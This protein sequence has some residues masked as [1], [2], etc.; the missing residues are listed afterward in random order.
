MGAT[1]KNNVYIM[2]AGSLSEAR[3]QDSGRWEDQEASTHK[4]TPRDG[5]QYS[6]QELMKD[7]H[8]EPSATMQEQ[9]NKKQKMFIM[10]SSTWDDTDINDD[11]KYGDQNRWVDLSDI[12]PM[13]TDMPHQ[14]GV[15]RRNQT[16]MMEKEIQ[17]P[18]SHS[19]EQPWVQDAR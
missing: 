10:R 17:Q 18:G 16:Q 3:S 5:K 4:I 12:E 15:F 7:D 19:Q 9:M 14:S 8:M 2:R 11:A 13:N 6:P 1:N